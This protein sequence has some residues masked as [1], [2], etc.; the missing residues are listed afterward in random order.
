MGMVPWVNLAGLH[1]VQVSLGEWHDTHVAVKAP[2]PSVL[3]SG[4][5][6]V[7]RFAAIGGLLREAELL[8]GLSHPN[9]IWLYGLVLP[10]QVL[11]GPMRPAH[12]ALPGARTDYQHADGM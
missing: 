6:G 1:G 7:T 9:I 2:Y 4:S 12:C 3:Q 8:S 10:E 11:Q 5:E